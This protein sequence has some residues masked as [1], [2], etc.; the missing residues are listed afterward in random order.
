MLP[1]LL[2]LVPQ[3]A[4]SP[5][6]EGAHRAAQEPA[7][8][9]RLLGAMGT[10]LR[11]E[12]EA[13]RRSEALR[14]SEAAA[15]EVEATEQRLSTWRPT[16]ELSRLQAAGGDWVELSAPTAHDL[17]A[18]LRWSAATAGRFDPCLGALIQAWELRG[19]G[20]VPSASTL[21]AAREASGARH[22][23]LEGTRARL[24][25]GASLDAGAFGKGAAL[26][27]ALRAST[28]AGALR[29]HLD[30]GGQHA[31]A[32][33]GTWTITLAHPQDRQRA[34]LRLTV[35]AGSVAT[36]GN[37]ER[38]WSAAG[39]AFG[40]LLDPA[41]GAP[42][43]PDLH[44]WTTTV[45]AP[46]ALAAD[47]LATAAFL[48]PRELGSSLEDAE[49]ALILLRVE[50]ERLVAELSPKFPHALE[51]LHPGLELRPDALERP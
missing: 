35:P 1:L 33:P 11:I 40:H 23:L 27:R 25:G 18:A 51:P 28:E 6:S 17:G 26:D 16:S 32:G 19:G 42:V 4:V 45:I 48:A 8:I 2:A 7:R 13:A 43:D 21:A 12:V 5:S 9:E 29:T 49:A 46:V 47:A 34:V 37:S 41:S 50:D 30:L 20:A 24:A 3:H 31:F 15:R 36:S 22:L 10:G 44:P 39:R 14:A 38:R